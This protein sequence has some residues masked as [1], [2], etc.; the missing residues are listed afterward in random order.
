MAKTVRTYENRMKDVVRFLSDEK[1]GLEG[2][3]IKHPPISY[4]L[5][6]A[7]SAANSIMR[8]Q[9]ERIDRRDL[10]QPVEIRRGRWDEYC[11]R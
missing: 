9:E 8:R 6:A 10:K 4:R 1:D 11:E 5:K 3:G 2:N 7:K